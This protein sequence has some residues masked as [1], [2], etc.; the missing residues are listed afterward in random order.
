MSVP[1][2]E[3]RDHEQHD[4]LI[5]S[6]DDKLGKIDRKL[7]LASRKIGELSPALREVKRVEFIVTMQKGK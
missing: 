7:I 1:S 2:D 4:D 6:V 3:Q 5:R